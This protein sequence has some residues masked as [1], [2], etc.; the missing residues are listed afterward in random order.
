MKIDPGCPPL[1]VVVPGGRDPF[2]DY[3]LGVPGPNEPHH[4][5]VNHHA[6]AAA[7]G[8][9]FH[10]ELDT[11]PAD[12]RFVLVLTP[13]RVRRAARAAAR[14]RRCGKSVLLGWK[15]CGEHQI[16]R[17]MTRPLASF[18]LRRALANSDAV[19]TNSPAAERFFSRRSDSGRRLTL[20]TPYP[21]DLH[22]WS[23]AR[24]LRERTGILV[25]T[26][27]WRTPSRRHG[28]AVRLALRIAE[29]VD[30]PVSV[31]NV[32]G[33]VGTRRLSGLAAG[34]RLRIVE[35][36]VPYSE[37]LRHMAGH[38]IVLQRDA[39]GVPGQ[40]AGDALLCGI[41]CLG[42]SGMVDG[43][44]F[45]HLPHAASDDDDVDAAARRLLTDDDAW[46][47]AMTTAR[48]R[49]DERLSFRA[50]RREWLRWTREAVPS[51][52]SPRGSA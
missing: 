28:Q 52:T 18:W 16:A 6:L 38:R 41:P 23:F 7:T 13:R 3:S 11:V 25:G 39:S 32:E 27:D 20:V 30:C 34:P 49:G 9:R 22:E 8:G 31:I 12:S 47:E 14:L 44:A 1:E 33:Q 43:L 21:I 15:E 51:L 2:A 26:R 24:P 45:P 37:Y 35:G 42:G 10:R 4:P 40:V 50:F 46:N 29:K 36:P 17:Q 48:A 5:P 19:L